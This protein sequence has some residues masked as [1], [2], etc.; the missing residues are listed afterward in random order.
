M[1]ALT[2]GAASASQVFGEGSQVTSIVCRCF[3]LPNNA[4]GRML[5]A[6]VYCRNLVLQPFVCGVLRT[7]ARKGWKGT[8]VVV[9]HNRDFVMSLATTHTAVVEDGKVKV[10]DRPPR[11]EDWEHDAEG[12][13]WK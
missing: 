13:G 11:P 12:Q 5:C 9:S 1:S 7:M 4:H 6:C 2:D 10:M 8:V 3:D